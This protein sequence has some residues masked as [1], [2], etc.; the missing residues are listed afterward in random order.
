[1][2]RI[3]QNIF[4]QKNFL[5]VIKRFLLFIFISFTFSL[6]V[7]SQEQSQAQ[8]LYDSAKNLMNRGDFENATSVI[9]D[10]LEQSPD[11]Y[12]I[13]KTFSL[14]NYLK[15]DYSGSIDICKKLV[16]RSDVDEQAYQILGMN[17]KAI[18]ETK[19]SAKMYKEALKK[20]PKSGILYNE[21][22]EVL[23]SDKNMIGAIEQWEKGIEVAPNISGNY[24]NAVNFYVQNNNLVKQLIYG[25]IFI[26]LESYTTR[27]ATVKSLLLDAYTKLY[28][29]GFL[30]NALNQS[31]KTSFTKLFIETMGKTKNVSFDGSLSEI[32]TAV[33]AKFILD[34]FGSKNNI[35]YPF[36]LFDYLQYL[37]R[38]GYF[39]AYNEWIFGAAQSPS[40]YQTWL[41][42]NTTKAAN[43][44]QFQQS[45]VFKIP[46]GQYYQ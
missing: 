46:V 14:I 3:L 26:N 21:Y 9:N 44:T 40:D 20:F 38:E 42:A 39:E 31:Q 13:L 32:L 22:G 33:R 17:Y 18:A 37:L 35:K 4:S 19:E 8:K 23:A 24:F 15:K 36:R 16:A 28:S 25:E 30:D 34:W 11:N 12:E 1:M 7:F 5:L 2:N 45:R 27:T 43:F 29:S 10:A 6:L 41:D